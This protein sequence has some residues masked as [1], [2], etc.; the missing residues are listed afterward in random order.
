MTWKH[1]SKTQMDK[2]FLI[3]NS[4]SGNWILFVIYRL[5]MDVIEESD[6]GSIGINLQELPNGQDAEAK[7]Q[8]NKEKKGTL[9]P[10]P[11]MLST[12]GGEIVIDN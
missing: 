10:F 8:I 11:H 4:Q 3:I 12:D 1:H 7:E 5:D 6:N 9:V 2:R